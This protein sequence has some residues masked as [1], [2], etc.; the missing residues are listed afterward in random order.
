MP[1]VRPTGKLPVARRRDRQ[2]LQ[3]ERSLVDEIPRMRPS[4]AQ[5]NPRDG[6]VVWN[7]VKSLWFSA[8]ALIGLVGGYLTFQYDAVAFTSALT[9]ATLCLG[10]SIGLHRLLIHRSFECPLWLEYLLVHLGTVVGMGGPFRMLYLHDI[11]D[12]SQRHSA[13]HPFFR[14]QGPVWRDLLWQL[15]CEMQLAHPPMFVI[16]PKVARDRVYKFMQH[17]WMLHQLPLALLCYLLG[18]WS[19]VVWGISVRV[20]ISLIGHSLVGHLAHNFGR[21]DW[22]LAGHAVQG[23]NVPGISLL[24]MGEGWHNNHH[25]F[26]RSARLGL[27]PMQ[28][29]PGW[30]ALL[31]MR[32]LGLVWNLKQPADLPPRS[33]LQALSE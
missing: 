14:N 7:W 33:E 4:T 31:T 26:P 19:Y 23:Y 27:H 5:T 3:H 30:W 28:F 12:W 21:R 15:H 8:H 6:V 2:S 32:T 25:A 13:C 1:P 24:T 10:H 11:R 17:T 16:E 22:H 20:A 18:G 9:M 29:D